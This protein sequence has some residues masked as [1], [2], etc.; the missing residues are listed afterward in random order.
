ML[1]DMNAPVH[2]VKINVSSNRGQTSALTFQGNTN[3]MK[4]GVRHMGTR[5]HQIQHLCQAVRIKTSH[6]SPRS[7]PALKYPEEFEALQSVPQGYPTH[8]QGLRDSSLG[9]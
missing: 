6:D 8:A 2:L 9:R 7:G 1:E 3:D 5:E 4:I